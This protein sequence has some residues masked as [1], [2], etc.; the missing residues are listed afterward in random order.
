MHPANG[1]VQRRR[2]AET[3]H[4]GRSAQALR[5]DSGS[6][7]SPARWEARADGTHTVTVASRDGEVNCAR[8]VQVILFDFFSGSSRS[9]RRGATTVASGSGDDEDSRRLPQVA[10]AMRSRLRVTRLK[11]DHAKLVE[12]GGKGILSD[13][14]GVLGRAAFHPAAPALHRGHAG[15]ADGGAGHRAALHLRPRSSTRSRPRLCPEGQRPA[16]PRGQGTAGDGLPR[17][18][19]PPLSRIRLHRQSRGRAGRRVGRRKAL[20][21]RARTL[22]E[23]FFQPRCRKP[24]SFASPTCWKRSTRCWSRTCFRPRRTAATRAS[25]PIAARVG[26]RL[27]TARSGGAFIGCSNYPECRYTRPFGPPAWRATARRTGWDRTARCWASTPTRAR[28]SG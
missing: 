11:P 10:W 27:R 20:Q 3:V 1:H 19:L 22:L 16:V 13:N 18:L 5:A 9:T 12:G 26:C 6:A 21:G 23:G 24:R 17:Q 25:A 4:R 2:V 15:Q 28:Q 8:P 7:P 14:G